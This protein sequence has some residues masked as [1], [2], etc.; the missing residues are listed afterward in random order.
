MMIIATYGSI[1]LAL[2]GKDS[3]LN[4]PTVARRMLLFPPPSPLLPDSHSVPGRFRKN[5]STRCKI[6]P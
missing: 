1:I 6:S 5:W 3:S 4:L 2:Y